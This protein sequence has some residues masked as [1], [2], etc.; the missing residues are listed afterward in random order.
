MRMNFPIIFFL[1]T[2]IY[3]YVCKSCLIVI[4]H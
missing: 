2:D 4:K 1:Y 3:R